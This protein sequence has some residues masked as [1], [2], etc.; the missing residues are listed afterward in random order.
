MLVGCCTIELI[1]YEAN[2]LKE[3]RSVVKSIIERIKAK[4]NVS[5]SEIG[6]NDT[7][8]KSIIG[9][10]CV[11][12]SKRHINKNISSVISYIENDYRVEIITENIEIL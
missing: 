8:R 12:N 2:S 11:S 3:K 4:F 10:A 7:L 6:A 9:F 5:I 1:I